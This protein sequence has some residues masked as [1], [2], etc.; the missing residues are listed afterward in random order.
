MGNSG[1]ELLVKCLEA[2]GVRYIFTV[3]GASI[4]P[5]LDVLVDHGPEIILCRHEQNA[6]F[7]AQAYGRIT[8]QP[9]VCMATAGPGLTNLVTGIAT[10]WSERSPVVAITGQLPRAMQFKQAHQ[11]IDSVGLFRPITKW[12][13]EV[14]HLESM[15]DI[16][17]GAFRLAG[18]PK[19]APT[20]ISIPSDI[21]GLKSACQP[22]APLPHPVGR[23]RGEEIA[24]AAKRIQGAKHP[25]ILL[26]MAAGKP[27]A[28]AGLRNFLERFEAPICATFEAAGAV[29]RKLVDRFMGRLGIFRNQPGDRVLEEADLV[30][31]IGFDPVEYDPLIW[32]KGLKRELIHIDEIESTVDQNYQPSAELIGDLP[33][34]LQ[35]LSEVLGTRERPLSNTAQKAKKELEEQLERGKAIDTAP[36]HP[37]RLIYEMRRLLSD[38][39]TVITDV[40]SH[41]YWMMR[42][43]F[44]FEASHLL[45]S[46][47]FQT[48][49][50]SIPYAIAATLARPGTK[51][52]SVSGDGSFLMCSMELETAVRLNS[53]IVHLV[54]EDGAYDLVKIQQEEKYGRDSAARFGHI[55]TVRYAESM[56]AKGMRIERPDQIEATLK[57]AL[58]ADGPVVISVPVDYSHNLEIVRMA[59]A[60]GA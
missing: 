2:Q 57:A 7:M 45:T 20:H 36:I 3:P 34:N 46:M 44:C 9:G 16:V 24:K 37:L 47:G 38:E 15:P 8:G 54:W 42:H 41:Q 43:Y 40:G 50:I 13:C 19:E 31:A 23:A 56:G 28:T 39:V 12:S 60:G 21:L 10:A 5:I 1:A 55:D 59:H 25:V 29:P 53:P 48:M 27:H 52:V 35:K 58:E 33:T 4:D 17:A 26:G 22:V 32:N 14:T 49:G 6:A 11:N 18:L 51:V 30:V